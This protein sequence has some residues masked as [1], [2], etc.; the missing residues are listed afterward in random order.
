MRTPRLSRLSAFVAVVTL[1]AAALVTAYGSVTT[2]HGTTG[3]AARTMAKDAGPVLTAHNTSTSR[4]VTS[5][6]SFTP[7]EGQATPSVAYVG[8]GPGATVLFANGAVTVELT[9]ASGR[10]TTQPTTPAMPTARLTAPAAKRTVS[11]S[12]RF[13]HANPHPRITG[14]ER[15]PGLVSYFKGANPAMWHTGIAA[16]RQVVYHDLWPGIDA[17]FSVNGGVLKYSFTLAPGADPSDIQLAYAGARHLAVDSAGALAITAPGAALRDKAPTARQ[18]NGL[19]VATAYRMLSANSFGFTLGKH[20]AG[21]PVV[22]DPGLDYAT[23]LGGTQDD[24]SYSIGSDAAGDLYVFGSAASPD[25][26][27]TAGA[28]QNTLNV[29]TDAIGDADDFFVTKF[30]PTGTKLIYSTFIG[31]SG[32]E[33]NA[34]GVVD[35]S[36][37]AYVAGGTL[38]TDFPVT[39]GAYRRQPYPSQ[40]QSVVFELNPAGTKLKFSTYLAPDTEPSGF[41][42]NIALGPDGSVIVAAASRSDFAPTTPGAFQTEYPGGLVASYVARL[43][44]SGSRLIYATYLGIPL[45]GDSPPGVDCTVQAMAVD[46]HGATYAGLEC[47]DGFPTTPGAYQ[48]TAG[49]DGFAGALLVKLD[50]SGSRLDYATYYGNAEQIIRPDAIAVDAAGDAYVAADVPAGDAPVTPD[51]Y[52]SDCGS[53]GLALYCTAIAEFDPSGTGLVYS[54]YF[55]GY[56]GMASYDNPEGLTLDSA[57]H[58]YLVGTASTEDIPTTPDAYARTPDGYNSPFFLA[59][60]G[61]NKLLYAT[62][63][64]GA[65]STVCAGQI[66]GLERGFITIAPQP[67]SGTVRIGGYT[68]AGNMPVSPGAFQTVNRSTSTLNLDT[69]AA[70]L[71]L[72]PLDSATTKSQGR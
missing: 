30:D 68:A 61:K 44:A 19:A 37:D 38:S 11:L 54:T 20:R 25:F 22:I 50:P 35:S 2:G 31:G 43:N 15:S 1:P 6:I 46:V 34:Y 27:V 40:L 63:F 47:A 24:W 33:Q 32:E 14:T 21:V 62:Y 26:P 36:G 58:L 64:G 28:Y 48:A 70:T 56:T 53:A 52:S 12:L 49:G 45:T 10:K 72:P 71:T 18:A 67:G 5:P 65:G 9:R 57:G 17:A 59:V 3:I 51:A 55:G 60:F 23:Y 16:F 4:A 42:R 13:L 66:C 69:W 29:G 39:G 8:Q 41:G 7:N